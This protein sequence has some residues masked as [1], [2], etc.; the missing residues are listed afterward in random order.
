MR[1][2]IKLILVSLVVIFAGF[3]I[4]SCKK[5]GPADC[6]ITVVDSNGTRIPQATVILKQDSVVNST[7]GV[8]AS[9]YEEGITD[10][11]GSVS[12][13]FKLEAVLNIEASRGLKSG[14]D[15]IRLEQSKTV[16]KS[17]VIR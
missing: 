6:V 17:V 1:T 3:P 2:L 5:T 11:S 13:S 15:F 4:I 8:Q 16:S 7:T 14:R 10:G 12:F 9:I